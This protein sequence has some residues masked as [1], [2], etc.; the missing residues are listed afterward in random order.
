MG[1]GTARDLWKTKFFS[2][3]G[4][5]ILIKAVVQAVPTYTMSVF[6]LPTTLIHDLQSLVSNFWW[7]GAGSTRKIHWA[8]WEQ[9]IKPK[10]DGSLGFW[11]LECF[12]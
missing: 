7:G 10:S 12:N 11:D 5:E 2:S 6:R 4:R 8:K 1:L 3:A 9:L